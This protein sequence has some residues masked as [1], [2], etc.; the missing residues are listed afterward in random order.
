[1]ARSRRSH[2]A[3]GGIDHGGTT[4]DGRSESARAARLL[5]GPVLVGLMLSA[6]DANAGGLYFSDRGVRPMGRAGAFVAGADDLGAV[7]YNPAG[8]ADAKTSLLADFSFLRFSAEYTRE[9]R[10]V[11]AD[12]TVRYLKSPRV[13][14][15]SPVIPF[16]TLAA[17]YNFG[18][19]KEFTV[20]AAMFAPYAAIAT[21]P[22]R[23]NGQPSPSRYALGSFDGSALVFTGAY[24]AYKPM[25][26]LRLGIGLGALVGIFQSTVTFSVSPPDRL[27]AAPEQ[28]DYDAAS[29]FRVGPIVAPTG[30][31]GATWVPLE[32][33]RVGTSLQLPA[34]ISSH[35]R[36]E[37]RLPSSAVFDGGRVTGTD[38]HVR[39]T[40]PAIWRIGAE[41]RPTSDLRAELTY[42]REFWSMHDSI[43]LTP[44]GVAIEGVSGLPRRVVLPGIKFPRGFQDSNSYRFGG[45]Y[46]FKLW[47]YDMTIRGGFSYETSAIPPEYL[48]L[49]T[50]DMDKITTA[51]GGGVRIGDH[52]RFD[53]TYAHLFASSVTVSPD[54]AKIPRV[55]PLPGN[56]IPETVNGGTYAASADLFGV[57]AQYTF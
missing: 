18:D 16:P 44:E 21:Y 22:E 51:I 48:S 11:D 42:V 52:W 26:Q 29:R 23:I 13:S 49:L 2:E 38:A 39:F 55:N 10:V 45:E 6:A 37:V 3:S 9:L 53:A 1:M 32:W 17:S 36:F 15:S 34:V 24:F 20:A 50:I 57:G 14:G 40:L 41:I 30:N 19:K 8:L 12:D 7:W 33:F 25:E 35:T 5:F 4:K 56:A 27:L 47:G 31:L 54:D 43:E 28:P 46:G